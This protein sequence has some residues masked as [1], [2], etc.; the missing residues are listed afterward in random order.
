MAGFMGL[1]PGSAHKA[2]SAHQRT[3]LEHARAL[4]RAQRDKDGKT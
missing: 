3:G 4:A 2:G 1:I